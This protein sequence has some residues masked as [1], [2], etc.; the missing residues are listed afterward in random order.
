MIA[1]NTS[2]LP[3]LPAAIRAP[4]YD[5]SRVHPGIVHVGVGSF[6]R[7]HQAIYAQR[8][9]RAGE[10]AWG[11]SGVG[12]LPG[13]RRMKTALVPQDCLYSVVIKR[14]DGEREVEVVGSIRE[15]LLVPDDP[16]AVVN[17]LADKT[18]RVVSLTI[19]EGGYKVDPLTGHLDT[20]DPD[21]AHD[22][23]PSILP[24]TVFGLMVT[25]LRERRDRGHRPFTV[26]SCDNIPGNGHLTRTV[27][28]DFA[29]CLDPALA[30]WI[31]AEVAFPNSM[32]DRITPA[33]GE[34]D[35]RQLADAYG[36]ADNWPVVC[37]PYIQW[38]LEDRFSDARPPLDTVGV[39]LVPDVVPYELLKIRLLNGGHQAIGFLGYLFGYEYVHQAM[40]DTLLAQFLQQYMD[41][42]TPTLKT[43]QDVDLPTYKA[44]I[45][46]RFGNPQIADTLARICADSSDRIPKFVLPSARDLLLHGGDIGPCALL[47][48]AWSRYAEGTD[49]RGRPI[50]VIDP[51]RDELTAAARSRSDPTAFLAVREVFGNLAENERFRRAFVAAVDVIRNRG[52]REAVHRMRLLPASR[53]TTTWS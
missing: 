52:V 4:G 50:T 2:C 8:L 37:E 24:R 45:I 32:V 11:I 16:S 3:N 44:S 53:S 15:Y 22:L 49:E 17:R 30:E 46:E 47:L 33:T 31:E 36:L 39:R 23:R 7:S 20:T 27:T 42:V 51:M 6:H 28:T 26:M 35:R 13:D 43:P 34:S 18:T 38:V 41:T 19:T 10:C 40:S 1:L 5:R 9:L 21:V 48:A 29:R 25:A 14:P 12:V